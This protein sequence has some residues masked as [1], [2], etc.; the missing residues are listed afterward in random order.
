MLHKGK[1][2]IFD[3]SGRAS[4]S[5][6]SS[7]FT[8]GKNPHLTKHKLHSKSTY[9]YR[10]G[11][12]ASESKTSSLSYLVPSVCALALLI[13]SI[14]AINPDVNRVYADG[15]EDG[16]STRAADS[17]I[18]LAFDGT[19]SFTEEA[20]ADEVAYITNTFTVTAKKQAK[21]TLQMTAMNGSGTNLHGKE[22]TSATI[23][24]VGENVSPANFPKNTWGYALTNNTGADQLTTAQGL[25]YSSM[26]AYGTPKNVITENLTGAES[27]TKSYLLAFAAKIGSD[28]PADHYIGNFLLSILGDQFDP[29]TYA[30]TYDGNGD[31][32]TNV[33]SP[34]TY[35]ETSVTTSHTFTISATRPTRTGYTFLGWAESSG[36]ATASHQPG[37]TITVQKANLNKTL[38]AVWQADKTLSDI[39]TMQEVTT[40]ICS[41]TPEGAEVKLKDTR[42]SKTYSVTR[43]KDGNCWM[44][45]NLANSSYARKV[46]STYGG[47]YTYTNAITACLNI[48][49]WELPPKDAYYNLVSIY[50]IGSD[51]SKLA[52]SPFNFQYGGFLS[53]NLPNF[54]SYSAYYVSS[55]PSYSNNFF[56]FNF[57]KSSISSP[58]FS[59]SNIDDGYAHAYSVRCVAK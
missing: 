50:N 31:N 40:A 34:D 57:G 15:E 33:P 36:A 2:R 26:P 55:T 11:S 10:W 19:P 13:G 37:G 45:Q 51:G 42:D 49:G 21:F 24:G 4:N 43:L 39:T 52:A 9:F 28:S 44:T 22:N 35:Q 41:A 32:V 16:V 12:R 3:A 5:R 29:A 46:D 8:I 23:G 27:E 53:D 54:T 7:T 48:T 47:Y 38:Y 30:L 6:T 17:S 56:I 58:S 59:S 1:P 20:K 25:D 14:M 18:A